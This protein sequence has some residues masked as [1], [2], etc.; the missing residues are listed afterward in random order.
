MRINAVVALYP[1]P[2]KSYYDAQFT[3][4]LRAGHDLRIFSAEGQDVH[5][6]NEKVVRHGLDRRTSHYPSTLKD[7][8]RSFPRALGNLLRS[9]G[10]GL[11]AAR[12]AFRTLGGGKRGFSGAFR[13]L[14]VLGDPDLWLVHGMAPAIAFRWL[15]PAFPRSAVAIYYHG[16][17]VPSV[18][19]LEGGLITE[20]FN[21]ADA[22][23][24]NTRFSRDHAV[25]RG[26]PAERIHVLPVGFDPADFPDISR[27]YRRDGGLQLIS[28]GRMSEEKGLIYALEA[29]RALLDSGRTR[30]HYSL[31][32]SGYARPDLERFVEEN[33][34]EEHVTFLGTIST[35]ELHQRM[36]ASDVL[37]LPSVQIGNWVEN[38]AC[39]VQEAML[40][41]L[42]VAASRTGGVPECVAPPFQ[43]WIVPERDASALARAISEIYDLSEEAM[44]R[45]GAEGRRYVLDG[46]DLSRIDQ[47]LVETA[48]ASARR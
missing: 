43:R 45:L 20:A 32:G 14:H 33:R 27:A 19:P 36:A 16:G 37:L 28:A 3:D 8:P 26:A 25:S 1:S 4:L 39:A 11:R 17:E 5:V 29:L 24:T 47:E 10:P 9:P 35:G 22:I 7:L 38:Q 30:V 12:A 13:A 23:F 48:V 40:W 34:L 41:K 6:L 15:K 31:T 44:A 21:G 2:F 42:V 46:F 18:E